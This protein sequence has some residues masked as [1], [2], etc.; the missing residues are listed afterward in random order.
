MNGEFPFEN[1]LSPFHSQ[2]PFN[3]QIMEKAYNKMSNASLCDLKRFYI[4]D[5]VVPYQKKVKR[6]KKVHGKIKKIADN[7]RDVK[8]QFLARELE[9]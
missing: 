1:Y 2:K 5:V 9:W 8:K 7:I 6:F 4:D 3:A